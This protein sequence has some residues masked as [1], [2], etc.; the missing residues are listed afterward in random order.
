MIEKRDSVVQEL[1]SVRDYIRWGTS[2]FIGAGLHFGH[3]F[4][5][6]WDEASYLVLHCLH[7]P[8]DIT[9]DVLDAR[10]TL[11][12][13]R[14]VAAAIERRVVERIPAAYVTGEAWFAGLRFYV[15]RRVLVPRSPLAELIEQGFRPWLSDGP[16]RIL[17]LCTGSGCI[18]IACAVAFPDADVQ[19]SD[20]SAEALAVAAKNIELHQLGDRVSCR[21]SDLF[22]GLDSTRYDLIV[23]NPPYVDAADLAAMPAE[24]RAEP[25]LGL[26]SGPDGLDFTRR[27]LREAPAHLNTGGL[28]VVEVGNSWAALEQA[29]P[30]VPFT[31]VELQ[32]G[33]HGI[34]VLSAAQ[35]RDHAADF[36]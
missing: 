17:D 19:L 6:A 27:L 25:A 35:L 20:I 36:S 4:D 31:W 1:H 13:R 3:G 9:P 5:N 10:L 15:D 2:R 8:W 26:G 14:A 34:F 21:Q 24:Y 16:A 11:E 29:Y 28:L 30:G 23:A 7:L 12:E 22:T 33:G 32:R 18:G